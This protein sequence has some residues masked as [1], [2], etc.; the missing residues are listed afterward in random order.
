MKKIFAIVLFFIASVTLLACTGNNSDIESEND[1]VVL[2]KEPKK[3][4]DYPTIKILSDPKDEYPWDK[5]FNN[6]DLVWKSKLQK[7]FIDLS[8]KYK[9][10]LEV[11]KYS[12]NYIEHIEKMVSTSNVDSAIARISTNKGLI[13]LVSKS[14]LVNIDQYARLDQN[15]KITG[16][17]ELIKY[18][19]TAFQLKVGQ[20]SLAE[21][22]KTYTKQYAISRH[23]LSSLFNMALYNADLL[24]KAGI[25]EDPVQLW[26]AGKW[27]WKKMEEMKEKLINYLHSSNGKDFLKGN[28]P[29]YESGK[30]YGFSFQFYLFDLIPQRYGKTIGLE[31]LQEQW[32]IDEINS[33]AKMWRNNENQ[34]AMWEEMSHNNNDAKDLNDIKYK[35]F[36]SEKW[37]AEGWSPNQHGGSKAFE[38]GGN[39]FTIAEPW[40]YQDAILAADKKPENR[41]KVK[42]M[43]I[44]TED[45]SHTNAK[46]NGISGDL[47]AVTK[48][49]HS[50][51]ATKIM[52][53]LNKVWVEHNIDVDVASAR[54]TFDEVKTMPEA[55]LRALVKSGELKAK[56][57]V[58]THLL[59]NGNISQNEFDNQV[60]V[61]KYYSDVARLTENRIEKYG[62]L[63]NFLDAIHAYMVDK[64]DL[65]TELTNTLR[66]FE[67]V[68][69]KLLAELK[70]GL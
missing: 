57:W 63:T 30:P 23:K 42:L 2:Y 70:K 66:E 36:W 59:S 3:N 33:F 22:D 44:P 52:L 55:D 12:G 7:A 5:D 17:A 54:K 49:K 27:T 37:R 50:D 28:M 32:V 24:N 45:G 39:A 18:L 38:K 34:T 47:L 4:P 26:K 68:K 6:D 29:T 20:L 1:G 69:T 53:E 46:I 56:Q 35:G 40:M 25:F 31:N 61:Y 51:L 19:D 43:P 62:Q 60:E 21:N 13:D 65:N 9:V 14:Y 58:T 15:D 16:D 64:L 41:G 48:G 67:E 10:N 11:E 8:K